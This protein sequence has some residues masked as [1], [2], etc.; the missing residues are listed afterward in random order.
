MDVHKTNATTPPATAGYIFEY[1]HGQQRNGTAAIVGSTC[2]FCDCVSRPLWG[3]RVVMLILAENARM[4]Y[5]PGP[6][7][8]GAIALLAPCGR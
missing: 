4:V 2:A 5:K 6:P 7:A 3:C 1:E 8:H